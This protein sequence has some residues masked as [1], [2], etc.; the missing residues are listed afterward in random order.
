MRGGRCKTA[1][2]WNGADMKRLRCEDAD[3]KRHSCNTAKIW[4]A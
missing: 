4:Y 2:M 3:I 1:E